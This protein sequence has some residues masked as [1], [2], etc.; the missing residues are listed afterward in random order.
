[1]GMNEYVVEV[2]TTR[3]VEEVIALAD[4]LM[5]TKPPRFG[6]DGWRAKFTWRPDAASEDV[7]RAYR[8]ERAG[9]IVEMM[10]AK[11]VSVR[12]SLLEVWSEE[13]D[14]DSRKV[15][16]AGGSPHVNFGTNSGFMVFPKYL[17]AF[18]SALS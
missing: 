5:L 12:G 2:V 8:L 4:E 17:T 16:V 10:A 7:L 14:G 3:S 13:L 11:T 15:T 9:A 6:P 18:R 1:M